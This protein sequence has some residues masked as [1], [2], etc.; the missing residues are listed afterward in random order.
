MK[1]KRLAGNDMQVNN[2]RMYQP[3][4]EL[5]AK[6]TSD[7]PVK[8]R[9]PVANQLRLIRAVRKEKCAAN[10]LRKNVD[11]VSYG[12]LVTHCDNEW[13]YFSLK[14]NGDMI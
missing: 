12:K 11:A 7:Q 5:I 1:T 13:V 6:N 3:L 10:M 4:W 14:Y 2:A 9:C 8:V